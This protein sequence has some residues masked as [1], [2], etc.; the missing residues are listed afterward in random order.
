VLKNLYE[1]VESCVLVGKQ[2][3]EWFEVE[4]GVRQG[5]ILSP[6]LFAIWIDGL[7]RALKKTKVKSILQNIK[8]NFTFFADDLAVL[9]ES[10][11]DLQKT[12]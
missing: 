8:F 6:I 5:C 7:A 9:A 1:V 2:R 11:N 3:S 12:A 4:A 10:R